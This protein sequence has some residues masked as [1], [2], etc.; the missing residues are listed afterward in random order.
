MQCLLLHMERR[1]KMI[2]NPWQ[3]EPKDSGYHW[4][5]IRRTKVKDWGKPILVEI[6]P[7]LDVCYVVASQASFLLSGTSHEGYVYLIKP[8]IVPESPMVL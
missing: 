8:V 7:D 2:D 3:T 6:S 4:L 1:I 5:V